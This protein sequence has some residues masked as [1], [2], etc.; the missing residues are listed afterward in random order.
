MKKVTITEQEFKEAVS[1]TEQEME[2]FRIRSF[3]KK[4]VEMYHMKKFIH[5]YRLYE[6][7]IQ[8][9]CYRQINEFRLENGYKIWKGQRSLVRLWNKPF[10]SL[11]WQYC[12]D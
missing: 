1:I 10:D 7:G 8:T 5:V 12:N 9:E 11:E 4:E 6:L 3:T 2:N